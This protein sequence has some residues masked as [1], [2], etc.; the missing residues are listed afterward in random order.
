MKKK[1]T[2]NSIP[3]VGFE[4]GI[5]QLRICDH[6][7]AV[8]EIYAALGINNRTSYAD[9]KAGRIEMRGQQ[10]AAVTEVFRKYGVTS[11]IWGV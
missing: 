5:Q 1:Q 10:I 2:S 7:E 11:N 8:A 3:G 4:R 9:Y 6:K